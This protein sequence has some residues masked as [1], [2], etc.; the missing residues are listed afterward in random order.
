ME[1]GLRL[2]QYKLGSSLYW[3]GRAWED[4]FIT[5]TAFKRIPDG[6]A[7]LKEIA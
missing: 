1:H 6:E 3:M 5:L 7:A 2:F 4:S